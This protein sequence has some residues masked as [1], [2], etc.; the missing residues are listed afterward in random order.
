[1]P[2]EGDG[3]SKQ[4]LLTQRRGNTERDDSN[5]QKQILNSLVLREALVKA[6]SGLSVMGYL[7]CGALCLLL[8][9]QHLKSYLDQFTKQYSDGFFQLA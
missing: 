1:M 3:R 9:A 8:A 4:G 7:T 2:I 5:L 6:V